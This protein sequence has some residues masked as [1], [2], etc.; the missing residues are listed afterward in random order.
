MFLSQLRGSGT[1]SE[2]AAKLG[3]TQ[4]AV[5]GLMRGDF[6][7]SYEVMQKFVELGYNPM[8]ML[9]GSGPLKL[10][11]PVQPLPIQL[12]PIADKLHKY[13]EVL[14]SLRDAI[15]TREKLDAVQQQLKAKFQPKKK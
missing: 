12:A 5:S 11:Q 3:I 10:D 2:L 4:G 15:E 6:L 14:E 1:Q 7:P 13:P 9:T 8:A